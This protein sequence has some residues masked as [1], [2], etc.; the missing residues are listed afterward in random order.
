MANIAASDVM[1]LRKMT[2]SGMMDCKKALAE[3]EGDFDKAIE[4]LR[5]KGQ[6]V[7]AKRGDRDAAEGLVIAKTTEDQSTGIILMLN[8]E[9]DF[10]AKNDDFNKLANEFAD[11][12]ISSEVAT[13]E[14][15]KGL[16]YGDSGI[17]IGEKITE[18]IGV[19]GEKIDISA[20]GIVKAETVFGYEHP[21]NQVGAL[22]GVNQKDAAEVAKT[23]AMQVAAMN[24][25]ALSGDDV[26]AEVVEKEMEIGRDLARQEGK[27]EEMIDRIAQGKLKKFFKENTLLN[28]AFYKD[29][30]VSVEQYLKGVDKDLTVTGFSRLAMK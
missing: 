4:I 15:L 19:I 27:P 13:A 9:T 12:A 2:G 25:V 17:T 6:K 14:D 30:K 26:P 24:P 8:C 10:V 22:V 1:K 16:P 28:Q 20:Y 7:A 18:Q 3:A 5:K 29:S 23:V 11:A 21:G